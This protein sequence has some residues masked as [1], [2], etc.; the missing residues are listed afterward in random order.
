MFQK[1]KNW[2]FLFT[3]VKGLGLNP[4]KLTSLIPIPQGKLEIQ[5]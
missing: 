5:L 4:D 3:H 1:Q 2:V